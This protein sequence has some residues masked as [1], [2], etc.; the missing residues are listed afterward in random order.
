MTHER[1][2]VTPKGGVS[3]HFEFR[4]S[5]QHVPLPICRGWSN[6]YNGGEWSSNVRRDEIMRYA[7]LYTKVILTIIAVLL[8]WD[9]VGRLRVSAVHAQSTSSR[10]YIEQITADWTSK[11][12]PTDLVTAINDAAKGR[13]LLSPA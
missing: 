10:Y 7:D 11:Q 4:D 1:S 5:L 13:Q 2:S 9:V 3:F 12:Y 8:V 6:V